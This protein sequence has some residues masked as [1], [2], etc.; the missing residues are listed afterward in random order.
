MTDVEKIDMILSQMQGMKSEL[1]D[2]K[3]ELQSMKR[4]MQ[5]V[6]CKVGRLEIGQNEIKKE[7]I[8]MDRRIGDVYN[9]AL[10]AWGQGVEN[11]KWLEK[12][13]LEA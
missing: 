11:R 3:S 12:Q 7:L 4:D 13:K 8:F 5:E 9:L 1:Q 6:N 2:M 10:D